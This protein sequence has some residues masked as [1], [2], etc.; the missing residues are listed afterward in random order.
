MS[1]THPVCVFLASGIQHAMRMRHVM[2]PAPL[3][4]IYPH[5]FINGRIYE[6]KSDSKQ[7]VCFDFLYNFCLE[8]FSF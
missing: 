8:H 3:Y 2:W 4:S 5:Y 6:K 1:I 7:T